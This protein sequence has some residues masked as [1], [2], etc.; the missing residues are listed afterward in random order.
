[1]TRFVAAVLVVL[2]V[3]VAACGKE[4]PTSPSETVTFTAKLL[5]ASEVPPVTNAESGGSSTVTVRMYLTRDGTGA[6]TEA[7]ADID[8]QLTGF[9]A[10]TPVTAVHIHT[11]AVGALGPVLV[12]SGISPTYLRLTNGSGGFTAVRASVSVAA[13]QSILANPSGVYVD[14][15][16]T[17]NPD[18]VAR[19]QLTAS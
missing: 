14:A 1:M 9:P 10:N 12:D 19:G 13:A 3:S 16:T 5:P 4:S 7:T 2:C 11:G 8:V 6:I 18:G 15:H 17:L